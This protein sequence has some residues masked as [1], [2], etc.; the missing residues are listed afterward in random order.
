MIVWRSEKVMLEIDFDSENAET[1][2]G[3][4]FEVGRMVLVGNKGSCVLQ[5]A[6]TTRSRRTAQK[7]G[8]PAPLSE[9]LA[10][11]ARF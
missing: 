6:T 1:E 7:V 4:S 5:T 11:M 9:T 3:R 10:K 2:F 8:G